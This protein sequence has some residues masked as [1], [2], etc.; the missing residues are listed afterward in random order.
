MS[1]WRSIEADKA[2]WLPGYQVLLCWLCVL[3]LVLRL[4]SSVAPEPLG[5]SAALGAL[6]LQRE[7]REAR[8]AGRAT[9]PLLGAPCHTAICQEPGP[10]SEELQPPAPDSSTRQTELLQMKCSVI[11]RAAG[12][13]QAAG[14]LYTL[15][16]R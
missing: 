14:G 15:N 12:P 5:P 16:C 7:A 9:L 6:S 2:L 4:C 11:M 1:L 13:S 3:T 10:R 8:G